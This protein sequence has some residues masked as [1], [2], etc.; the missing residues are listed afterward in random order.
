VTR[1]PLAVIRADASA[2][3]GTGHVVRSTALATALVS[4]GWAVRLATYALPDGLREP[5]T[6]AGLD[7]VEVRHGD[8]PADEA[9]AIRPKLAAEPALI[10]G[11]HYGLAEAWW[12]TA[13]D[14][15]PEALLLA[16]DDLAAGPIAAD[17][18]LNPNLGAD[19]AAYRRS[20]SSILAGP[21]Y[22]IVRPRFA[23]LRP[24]SLA[25]RRGAIK[26]IF[27][28]VGGA[29]RDNVT[30]RLARIVL[31][32]SRGLALAVDV[33]LGAAAPHVREMAELVGGSPAARLHVNTPDI[34]DLM[35]R[36]DLAIGAPSSASWE[37]CT[38]GLP[39]ITLTIV[40][41]QVS[42][43]AALASNG[44]SIS[45][46]WHHAVTDEEMAGAIGELLTDPA[47]VARMSR[48]AA[49]LTD[50]RGAERVVDAIEGLIP[51]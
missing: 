22:A 28:F 30:A 43:A 47:R 25:R 42:V 29:D 51:R 33:V 46:G 37:R 48:A 5:W 38:L 45:L 23:E 40:D 1:Q 13:R 20:P 11:D 24:Q 15:F 49:D 34:A 36:A 4:H 44:A 16:V 7:V 10:V 41:N 31:K 26:R 27:V 9:S 19:V 2:A 8:A 14:A 39:A 12:S 3:I 18:I 35:A 32:E 6:S 50:G 17:L 21:K